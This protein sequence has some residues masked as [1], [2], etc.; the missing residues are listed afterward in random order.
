MR[1]PV[2]VSSSHSKSNGVPSVAQPPH[3]VADHLPV[4]GRV[5]RETLVQRRLVPGWF[6]VDGADFVGPRDPP[7]PQVQRPAADPGDATGDA[8]QGVALGGLGGDAP[9]LGDVAGL[10]HARRTTAVVQA[11]GGHFHLEDGPVLRAVPP[12]AAVLHRHPGAG[13]HL[14]QRRDVFR[15]PDV[16]DR[17]AEE[18]GATVAVLLHRG[19]VDGQ[20][21]ERLAV[22]DEQRVGN[23]VE[24]APVALLAV[25]QRV[26]GL[27]ALGHFREQG[28]IDLLQLERLLLQLADQHLVVGVDQQHLLHR[29]RGRRAQLA[30]R[31]P[32]EHVADQRH[33]YVRLGG[34]DHEGVRAEREGQALVL[35]LGVGGGVDDEGDVLEAVVGL[36]LAEQ[37]VAVEHRH[38]QVGD[39]QRRRLLSSP[40]QRLGAVTGLDHREAVPLEQGAQQVEVGV[41]VV[42]DQHLG[43]WR[44]PSSGG[45]RN[46]SMA[47]MNVSGSIGFSR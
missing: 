3:D 11:V 16:L 25:E 19:V 28:A 15:G 47:A 18:L 24:Q 43:H 38:Q 33:E 5:V 20:V 12:H 31:V 42:D 13:Q 39:D 35:R 17:H 1:R 40:G 36:A 6:I 7:G 45:V 21:A 22:V 26:L 32:I 44:D 9:L 29:G 2:A 37:R 10:D 8:Q 30:A 23:G 4:L 27:A 41:L 46:C 14:A 34:L